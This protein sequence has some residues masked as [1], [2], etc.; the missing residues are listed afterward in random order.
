[1][2]KSIVN[3][4]LWKRPIT[5]KSVRQIMGAIRDYHLDRRDEGNELWKELVAEEAPDV[6]QMMA[7]AKKLEEHGIYASYAARQCVD[8]DSRRVDAIKAKREAQ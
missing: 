2:D 6:E 5:S 7:L 3:D 4:P 8:Y 1:M